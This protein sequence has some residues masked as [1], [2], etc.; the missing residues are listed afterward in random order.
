MLRLLQANSLKC[1]I[2]ATTEEVPPRAIGFVDAY[3]I[4][5]TAL[6]A[7]GWR[8]I[9]DDKVAQMILEA[10]SFAQRDVCLIPGCNSNFCNL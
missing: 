7:M 5:M 3:D 6:D 9:S 1:A 8:D 2:I 4:A 10:K